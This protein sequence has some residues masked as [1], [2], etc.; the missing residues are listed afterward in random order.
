MG[1]NK[2]ELP[3]WIPWAT[4]TCLAALVACLCELWVIER[5][6]NHLL[7]EEAQLSESALKAATNQLEAERII[8]TRE[9]GGLTAA[10]LAGIRL[11]A[12]APAREGVRAP[13]AAA[14][15]WNPGSGLG[16][17]EI[18]CGG[19]APSGRDYQLWLEVGGGAQACALVPDAGGLREADIRVPAGQDDPRFVLTLGIKGGAR[20]LE[21][22]E[23]SGSIVLASPPPAPRLSGR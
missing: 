2:I 11:T 10:S 9:I 14:V 7:H 19:Q 21:E 12:L 23:R 5:A 22:A 8:S 6:R 17:V 4:T 15:A 18:V 3:A 1:E 20:T 13:A 16:V